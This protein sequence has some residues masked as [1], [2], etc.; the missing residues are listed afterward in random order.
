MS[1]PD[2]PPHLF[3]FG[4]G[5]CAQRLAERKHASGWTISGTGRGGQTITERRAQ[6]YRVFRFDGAAADDGMS[7][8]LATATHVLLS[9]PPGEDGDPAFVRYG[10]ALA[11]AAQL[12]W[13]GYLST[14]GVYGDRNG[15]WVD[16]T[17]G[18]APA[19]DR[20]KRRLAA[21]TAWLSLHA[22][23]GLPVHIF[24]LPGI[25]GPGR[26]AVEQVRAGTARR[27]VKPG[28]VFCR[29]HV[30]DIAGT[31]EASMARPR[32]GAV[33]NVCDDEPAANADVVA[34]AAHLLGAAPPPE[35]PFDSAE[36]SDMARSFYAENRRV[37][38]DLIKREL[39]V[40]LR[41]PTYREGLAAVLAET[42]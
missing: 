18:P 31:L 36:L 39:G 40:V 14:T 35:I 42:G 24:R 29:V 20:A 1:Q 33:Y 38:N 11:A 17:T 13:I 22:S 41:Y 25:Y 4:F 10:A 21:E 23:Y 37:R 16:E 12:Q 15:A 26:S 32:P 2:I 19:S 34:H 7:E 30:D 5:Y 6:G 8:A 27:I 3:C 9:I 28:Q